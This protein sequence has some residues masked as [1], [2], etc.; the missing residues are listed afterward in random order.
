VQR[1]NKQIN[2]PNHMSRHDNLFPVVAI[3]GVVLFFSPR[4]LFI[5]RTSTHA[6]SK[7]PVVCVRRKTNA[8]RARKR[9][10]NGAGAKKACLLL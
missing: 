10:V 9:K 3:V 5:M 1:K 6:A 4:T 2:N 7:E 8:A